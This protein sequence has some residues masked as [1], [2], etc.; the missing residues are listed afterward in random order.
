[1]QKE[2]IQKNV[3]IAMTSNHALQNETDDRFPTGSTSR[4]TLLPLYPELIKPRIAGSLFTR[5]I[6]RV[7]GLP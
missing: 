3:Q 7:R 5:K 6:D 1:V 4:T 2:G